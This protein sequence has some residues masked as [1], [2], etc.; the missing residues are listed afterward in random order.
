VALPADTTAGTPLTGTF[1]WTRLS[2]EVQVPADARRM[3]VFLGLAP[4]RGALLLD[5][6]SIKAR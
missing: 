3:R 2:A 1:D 5:D 4:A 6:I